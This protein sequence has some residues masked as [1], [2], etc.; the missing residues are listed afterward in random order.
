MQGRWW[1]VAVVGGQALGVS[2]GKLTKQPLSSASPP[3][4]VAV[5]ELKLDGHTPETILFTVAPYYGNLN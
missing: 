1:R 3:Y 5:K 4:R 2:C